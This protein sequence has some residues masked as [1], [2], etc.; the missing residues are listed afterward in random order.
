MQYMNAE[1]EKW[2]FLRETKKEAESAGKDE[3]TGLK[4]TGLEE[5]LTV[6]FPETHDW[7]HDKIIEKELLPEGVK[8]RKHPD[9][10][11][12][13]LKMIVE[14]DRVQHYG[15]PEKIFED[16]QA[17]KFYS[18]LGYK[19]VRI[20]FFIQLTNQAVKKLFDVEVDEPLF[21]ASYPSLGPLQCRPA[22]LC[23]AGIKRM[24]KEF[25]DFPDQYEANIKYLHQI[26]NDYMTGVSIL[27]AVYNCTS[28]ND[29]GPLVLNNLMI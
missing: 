10:R 9:Y 5:Y 4:R 20:P 28:K 2:G 13:S 26:D 25:K 27:E 14:F 21:N 1:N 18:S 12:E 19:V 29:S 15:N 8:T 6:I 23:L 17:T 22:C 11:S 24:A 7:V 16:E 3:A